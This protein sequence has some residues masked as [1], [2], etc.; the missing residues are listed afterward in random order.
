MMAS[1]IAY[2][3]LVTDTGKEYDVIKD[4]REMKGIS[5]SRTVYGEYD[6]F[7][8]IEVNDLI[9][10]DEIVTQVRQIPGVIKTTTLVGSP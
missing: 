4:V 7:I 6:V 9:I 1:V 3:L 10:M 2:M 8:R 5:E